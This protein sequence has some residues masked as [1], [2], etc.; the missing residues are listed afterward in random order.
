MSILRVIRIVV[1]TWNLYELERLVFC[2]RK[3]NDESFLGEI[4]DVIEHELQKRKKSE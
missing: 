1:K 4:I 2:L 3:E